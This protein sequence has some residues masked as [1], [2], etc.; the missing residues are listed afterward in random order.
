MMVISSSAW[1][2][3][4]FLPISSISKTVSTFQKVLESVHGVIKNVV[5]TERP[6]QVA[7]YPEIGIAA[8]GLGRVR[9]LQPVHAVR[10]RI[11]S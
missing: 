4:Y 2:S 6:V 7:R 9:L 1:G 11:V 5:S 10:T 3:A 8:E